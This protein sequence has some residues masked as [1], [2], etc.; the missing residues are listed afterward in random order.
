MRPRFNKALLPFSITLGVCGLLYASAGLCFA[1]FFSLPVFSNFFTD[2]AVLGIAALGLTFVIL[3]GEID[4]SVGSLVAFTS[5]LIAKLVTK[6]H[7]HPLF[8]SGLALGVGVLFGILQG[9]L[10]HFF[11]IPGFLVTLGGLFLARGL[12]FVLQLESIAME[13][14]FLSKA[15]DVHLSIA[16]GKFELPLPACLFLVLFLVA[17]VIAQYT[18][19]GRNVYALGGNEQSAA[20]MG[21]PTAATRVGVFAVSGFCSAL[22]GFVYCLYTFSGNPNAATGLEL[23]AIAAVVIGG[24]LLTGGVGY[25]AGTVVGVLIF[26]IIQTAIT[27]QGTLSSWWTKIVIGLL[28]LIFLLLQKLIQSKT[29]R[30][31]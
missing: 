28:L 27:F 12:S 9:L 5:M 3:S 25:I 1:G 10:V 14:P 13:H 2:N 21:L 15:A 26:G 18:R 23:D 22:A 16:N 4:L 24:T 8:A 31:R 7:W 6:N 19:F 11:R 29:V 20:L 17:F 30:G